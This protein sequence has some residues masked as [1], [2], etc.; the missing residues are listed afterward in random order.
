MLV[1]RWSIPKALAV[2]I[3]IAGVMGG[4]QA[5]LIIALRIGRDRHT[6]WPIQLM[7]GLSAALLAAGVLM[8]YWDIYVHRTVRGISFLFVFIDAMGDLTSL[9][10]VFFQPT[11]DVPGIVIYGLE[12]AL[13]CGVFACGGYFNLLPWLRSR[14]NARLLTALSCRR[15]RTPEQTEERQ[16]EGRGEA[17]VLHNL[18]SSSSVFQTTSGEIRAR[19][20]HSLRT[21]SA[22]RER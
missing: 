8:H 5:A 7:A 3:P 16:V 6:E 14:D 13:W 17:V 20:S 4:I 15:T 21:S 10:S 9:I 22:E 18:P 1:Q 12:L 19:D 11:L 2:V